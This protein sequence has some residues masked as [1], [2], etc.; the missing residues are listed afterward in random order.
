M[1]KKMK[2]HF[3]LIAVLLLAVMAMAACTKEEPAQEESKAAV[4]V[5]TT[6]EL[7]SNIEDDSWVVVDT[8]LNDAYNGWKLEGV[9]RG[10]HIKGAVDFSANW[11]KVEKENKESILDEALEAKGIA[12]DKNIVLYDA[13]GK[14]AAAVAQYL[15]GKGYENVYTYDVK[16]WAEDDSLP[17]EKYE[18][19]K[20]IVPASVVK[21]I[22]DGKTP[23]TFEEGKK[24]KMV[25]ASWGEEENSYA[26]GH[27][28]TAF[29][30]NT[31]V[32]E[33]PTKEE[34]VMWMM[35]SDKELA[36]FAL[37][38]GFTKD[39]TVI[40]SGAEQMAAYRVALVLNYMGVDDVRVLNGGLGA[41]TAAGYE[42]ETDSHKPEPVSDFGAQ[43]PVNP[44]VIDTIEEAKAGLAKPEEFTLVDNRTWEEHIGENSGYSYHDKKGR[45]PGSMFGYAG[46]TDSY[47][48]D[49]YRNID[50]TMRNADEILGLWDEAGLDTSKHLSF[51]CGSGWRVAEIYAYSNVMGFENTSVFS[52][53][54]IGWSNGGNPIETGEPAK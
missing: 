15:L 29:H 21:D 48:L 51:M 41:W 20:N 7:S 27:I 26:K 46:K 22:L 8:R 16:Q 33:P 24:V 36:Q 23:E 25:E 47:S 19:Y 9:K 12:K 1:G 28:P 35:A 50:G 44:D 32:I 31:D 34:P 39:D 3:L 40:V 10:G 49:Y 42:V 37:D 43:I 2:K 13:N 52:D 45:V 30:I 38:Y 14:D 53:G 17:M 4:N 6:E 11:L 5:I 18:N 54:W